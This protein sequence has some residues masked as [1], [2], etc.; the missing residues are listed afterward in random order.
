MTTATAFLKRWSQVRLLPGAPLLPGF[1]PGRASLDA[2]KQSLPAHVRST[3]TV[4][5]QSA[6][7]AAPRRGPEM[8]RPEGM[9][10]AHA[11]ALAR[12]PDRERE[13]VLER[14]AIR[15]YDGGEPWREAD[16]HALET[17]RAQGSLWGRR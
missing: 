2:R 1:L 16:A 3:K 15:H 6:R 5:V 10:L 7:L 17:E 13:H 8:A 12:L 14:A 4:H 9:S 11:E